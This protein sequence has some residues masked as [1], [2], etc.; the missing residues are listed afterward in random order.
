MGDYPWYDVVRST[1]LEQ[2]DFF[3]QCPV[4]EPEWNAEAWEREEGLQLRGAVTYY[5]VV[6]MSQSC[7]LVQDKLRSA[8]VCPFMPIEDFLAYAYPG[9]NAKE[10][11]T[12]REQIRQGN[13]PGYHMLA[14]CDIG[15][16]R[17]DVQII[18]FH[19]IYS[20]P[21]AM[22][23]QMAATTATS[24]LRLLPPYREHLGQAFAR[25]F[26]RVGLPIDIPKQ[27]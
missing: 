14:P 20:L 27:K 18:T 8:I 1:E 5:S 13:M 15:G 12:I 9:K 26:M 7:D 19:Q 10:L 6:I 2:G 21:I 24:R 17:H 16:F 4:L 22:L 23:K 11:R 3:Y 25:Y